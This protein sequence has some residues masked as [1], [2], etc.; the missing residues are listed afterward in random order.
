MPD[1]LLAFEQGSDVRGVSFCFRIRHRLLSRRYEYAAAKAGQRRDAWTSDEHVYVVVHRR[2]AD[3]QFDCGSGVAPFWRAAHA[4][5]WRRNYRRV[6]HDCYLAKSA[7][8]G[9]LSFALC[10]KRLFYDKLLAS[11]KRNLIW[12]SLV[13]LAAVACSALVIAQSGWT[14]TRVT[15]SGRDLN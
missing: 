12:T 10:A 2:D 6:C 1:W 3:W 11:V 14:P 9:T 5:R 8:A 4:G 7:A 13:M 15:S